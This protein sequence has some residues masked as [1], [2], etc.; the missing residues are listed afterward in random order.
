MAVTSYS[1]ITSLSAS[2]FAS[3]IA[4]A[5]AAGYQPLGKPSILPDKSGGYRYSQAMTVGSVDSGV[6][7]NGLQV[8]TVA[9]TSANILALNAT[10]ITLVAAPGAGKVIIPIRV[11]LKFTKVATAYTVSGNLQNLYTGGTAQTLIAAAGLLDQTVNTSAIVVPAAETRANSALLNLAY[12]IKASA[13][14]TTGDGTLSID[15]S[16]IVANAP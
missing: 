15:T 4:D 14:Q 16:Y 6:G 1:L 12:Q 7:T 3:Q 5:I 8:A 10:P 9:L 2:D 11:F 13:A